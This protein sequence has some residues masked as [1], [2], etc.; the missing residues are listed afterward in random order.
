MTEVPA[1]LLLTL[2]LALGGAEIAAILTRKEGDTI[3]ERLRALLGIR[4][5]RW[6]RPIGIIALCAL[7]AWFV[8]HLIFG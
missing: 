6:W 4:P 3:S 2:G 7:A 1:W 8:V 5:V